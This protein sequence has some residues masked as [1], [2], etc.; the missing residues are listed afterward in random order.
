MTINMSNV[1]NLSSYGF[2]NSHFKFFVNKFFLLA[3]YLFLGIFNYLDV[4]SGADLSLS[5]LNIIFII[6][7]SW[8]Y[9]RDAAM[10]Y[11]IVAA[12]MEFILHVFKNSNSSSI[13]SN[14]INL[15]INSVIY[16]VICYLICEFKKKFLKEKNLSRKDFLTGISN[17]CHFLEG[18][19][20]ELARCSRYNRPISVVYIDCDNFKFVND[21]F[22]HKAGDKVLVTIASLL[23][24][25]TRLTDIA[26]R[27]GGDEFALLLPETSAD[28]A[29]I[30]MQKIQ[31]NLLNAMK[32]KKFPVT[33]SIGIATFIAPPKS[34]NEMLNQADELM[35]EVKKS[36]KNAIKHKIFYDRSKDHHATKTN[37]G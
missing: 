36:S 18:S 9:N 2:G 19:L 13:S 11:A 17:R 12:S 4:T 1:E 24:R 22:G 16:I 29:K 10:F 37:L 6:L 31:K 33:F 7:V 8:K 14:F 28:Q 5:S 3:L 27:L 30:V 26:A 21:K 15:A 35:Y 32:L 34:V 23:V 20:V 25:N